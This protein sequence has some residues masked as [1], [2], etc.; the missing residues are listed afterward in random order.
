[1]PRFSGVAIWAAALTI[2][3]GTLLAQEESTGANRP[4]TGQ[5]RGARGAESTR[6]FLGLG[7]APDAAA[8]AKGEPLYK[9]N[10]ATCHGD[11]GR[12]A[13]GPNLIRSVVVLHDEKGE[14]IGP[15]IKN[16]RPQ[17]GMPGFPGLSADDRYNIAEFLHLQVELTANRGTYRNT[18]SDLRN[19]STGD[20]K[21]GEAYF[22]GE[23]GC[24]SCHSVSGDLANIGKK[25]PQAAVMQSHFLRPVGEGPLKAKI[26]LPDGRTIEGSIKTLDDFDVSFYDSNGEYHYYRRDQVGVQI[27][28]RLEGHR[29]LLSRYTDADIH[30]LTAYLVTLR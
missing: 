15:V 29:A 12:G 10:C 16:G 14:E 6:E 26:K 27:E 7:P 8:A 19:Q 9:Q 30:D 28:D 2:T 13:Q 1:M 11:K 18:Y 17:A 20:A 21:K 22:N 23:G 3:A 24:N 25:F 5:R 4:R